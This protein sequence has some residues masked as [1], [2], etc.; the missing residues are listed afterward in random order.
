MQQR[1]QERL[2]SATRRKQRGR[3][4]TGRIVA[5]ALGSSVA[6]LHTSLRVFFGR[7][8]EALA[9][10]MP[11]PVAFESQFTGPTGSGFRRTVGRFGKA[12]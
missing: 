5:S 3:K 2:R 6:S 4:T 12:G 9:P 10:D 1:R 8:N 11:E 7:V